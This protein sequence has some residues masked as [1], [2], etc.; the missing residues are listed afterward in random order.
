MRDTA[1]LSM[2]VKPKALT[3]SFFVRIYDAKDRVM[4]RFPLEIGKRGVWSGAK[5]RRNKWNS[6][7]ALEK[8]LKDRRC[9]GDAKFN[10]ADRFGTT[11]VGQVC[12][13]RSP[14]IPHPVDFPKSGH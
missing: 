5:I 9:V 14:Q 8:P 7:K 11:T 2:A 6:I 1:L 12:R 4:D 10:D 3:S 13:S